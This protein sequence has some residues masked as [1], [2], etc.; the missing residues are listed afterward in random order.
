MVIPVIL[1]LLAL[2]SG[3][4]FLVKVIGVVARVPL[5]RILGAEGTGLYQMAY[6][7]YGL[8]LTTITAGF[9]TTLSLTVAADHRFGRKMFNIALVFLILIG[10]TSGVLLF[11]FA[12]KIAAFYGEQQLTFAIRCIAFAVPIVPLLGLMRGFLQGMEF[13]G[14]IAFSEVIEQTIR[15]ITMLALV[16]LWVERSVEY[17]VGGAVMGAFLGGLAAFVFLL[18]MFLFFLP[19]KSGESRFDPASFRISAFGSN[20]I[21][22]FRMSLFISVTQFI[23]PAS[24]F[25]DALIIPQRLQASGLTIHEAISIFGE[26]TGMAALITYMPTIITA[27]VSHILSP[28]ITADWQQKRKEQFFW[29][30][31]LAL[32]M[33]LIWGV[34]S[35]AFLYLFSHDLSVLLFSTENASKAIRYLS[36]APIVAGMREMTT[37]IL[38]SM[39]KKREPLVGL[40]IGITIAVFLEYYLAGIPGF[41]Y[42]GAAIGL[43]SL[44]FLAAVWNLV[45]LRRYSKEF[46]LFLRVLPDFIFLLFLVVFLYYFS[47]WIGGFTHFPH[48]LFTIGRILLTYASVALYVLVRFLR[49]NRMSLF[50]W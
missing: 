45:V 36:I 30:S 10:G 42:K 8:V 24:E 25:F 12:P 32:E 7:I 15:A 2:R 48:L 16:A 49:V 41:G 20:V 14:Y 37:T 40:L 18:F 26:L 44:E 17:A 5:Y 9:P 33:G 29:R 3:A 35:A 22:F 4:I 13:Y 50:D 1:R 46:R 31:K 27:S 19:Q 23:L 28:K 34:G 43:I 21:L 39:G 38:W 11:L 47:A 6:S